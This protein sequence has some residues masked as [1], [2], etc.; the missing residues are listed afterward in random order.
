[1]LICPFPKCHR[2]LSSLS[3]LHGLLV[4]QTTRY[5]SMNFRL[6]RVSD[7]FANDSVDVDVDDLVVRA[8]GPPHFY[9][10]QLVLRWRRD[11][12]RPF[13]ARVFCRARFSCEFSGKFWI[14]LQT[15]FR[16][17]PKPR[18][19]EPRKLVKM[20]LLNSRLWWAWFIMLVG[21]L[22]DFEQSLLVLPTQRS[23]S[24]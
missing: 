13:F 3:P 1:M 16:A 4:I 7:G 20:F 19:G 15:S 23:N 11:H 6:R 17:V 9:S 24:I 5:K 10:C 22:S 14:S 8:G 12:K 2:G 21:D 18:L